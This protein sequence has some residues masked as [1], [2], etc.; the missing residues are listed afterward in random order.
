MKKQQI[1]FIDWWNT[2]ESYKDYE[3]YLAKIVFKK[4]EHWK[5][6]LSLDLWEDFEILFPDMPCKKFADYKAWKIMFESIFP[7][8]EEDVILLWHS[9][10]SGFLLKYLEENE[11]PVKIKRIIFVSIFDRDT[12][13]DKI[14]S[15][16]LERELKN[17]LKY[18]NILTFFHAKD[19]KV[20]PVDFLLKYKKILPNA[21]YFILEKW[22][23]FI[24]PR[25][26]ELINY[27]KSL[28]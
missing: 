17:F 25:F 16:W 22:N 5:N 13:K 19:D 2:K 12:E 14:W 27:I 6:S 28:N 20:C 11:F 18:E 24:I 9:L 21:E 4:R 7:F 1:L 10:W 15:F 3:D 8:L 23:H 26:L